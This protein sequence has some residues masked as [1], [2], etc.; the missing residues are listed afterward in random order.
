[1]GIGLSDFFDISFF[2]LSD[3]M[4][5]IPLLPDSNLQPNAGK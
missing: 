3:E 1:M 5:I 4:E 2:F